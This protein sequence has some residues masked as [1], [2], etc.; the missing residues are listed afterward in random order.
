MA[1]RAVSGRCLPVEGSRLL[2][3]QGI[4]LLEL[5]NDGQ[6]AGVPGES[7]VGAH[8]RH[9]L[10]HYQMFLRG[11]P[12]GR[13]DYDARERDPELERSR[14]AALAVT[15]RC[16]LALDALTREPDRP[17]L[18][19]M[20]T[21]PGIMTPDWRGSSAGRELQFLC[22]HTVHH[23]ALIRLLLPEITTGLGAEFGVAV[24]TLSYGRESGSQGARESDPSSQP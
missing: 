24:S 15:R 14:E 6:Y 13:I 3:A 22:S 20:E 1:G 5:L 8:Y 18:V 9:V 7:S 12:H 19:Q 17:L 10:D 4:A 16:L 2:L 23:F 11:L 21:E